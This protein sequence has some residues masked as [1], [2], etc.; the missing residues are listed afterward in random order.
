VGASRAEAGRWHRRRRCRGCRGRPEW[1]GA[2][3]GTHRMRPAAGVGTRLAAVE[4]AAKALRVGGPGSTSGIGRL[5]VRRG[6]EPPVGE[7]MA[8]VGRRIRRR[9]TVR[10]DLAGERGAQRNARLGHRWR[11]DGGNRRF[12]MGRN[13]VDST[14]AG[15][16][17]IMR[18]GRWPAADNATSAKGGDAA[19]RRGGASAPPGDRGYP[20]AASLTRRGWGRRPMM[21]FVSHRRDANTDATGARSG[22]TSGRGWE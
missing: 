15:F 7:R 11:P 14:G 3:R 6:T 18:G 8:V 9:R 13:W 16:G 12:P 20:T 4:E 1:A 22:A 19:R 21:G 5:S 17:W 10:R 2:D